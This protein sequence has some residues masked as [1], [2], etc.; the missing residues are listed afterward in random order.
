MSLPFVDSASDVFGVLA[1]MRQKIKNDPHVVHGVALGGSFTFQL[2]WL[3]M[4]I[5]QN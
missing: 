2:S 1:K 4:K 5:F 3:Q